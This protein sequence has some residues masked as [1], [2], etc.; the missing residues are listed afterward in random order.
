MA[1]LTLN[2]GQKQ[3]KGYLSV[4]YQRKD[5]SHFTIMLKRIVPCYSLQVEESSWSVS[6]LKDKV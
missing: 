3:E 5:D 6:S 4:W 2:F 1:S